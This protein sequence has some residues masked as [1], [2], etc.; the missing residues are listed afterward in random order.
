MNQLDSVKPA[1]E[2][3]VN[4]SA[5]PLVLPW[6]SF[7]FDWFL[8]GNT[9]CVRPACM[10]SPLSECSWWV[11]HLLCA[12]ATDYLSRAS[13]V[14]DFLY[15]WGKDSGPLQNCHLWEEGLCSL[16]LEL[17]VSFAVS[18]DGINVLL[19]K[20]GKDRV[21]HLSVVWGCLHDHQGLCS[22][23]VISPTHVENT[24]HLV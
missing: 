24:R 22:P 1:L 5:E 15:L 11:Q 12:L 9:D 8:G 14:H 10:V 6:F 7:N 13:T 17:G 19:S 21:R 23:G 4:S 3:M 16:D 18:G 20:Q 2:Q